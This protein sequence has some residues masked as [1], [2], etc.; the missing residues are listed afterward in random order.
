MIKALFVAV[1]HRLPQPLSSKAGRLACNITSS[2]E[3]ELSCR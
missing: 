2:K 1:A 3:A